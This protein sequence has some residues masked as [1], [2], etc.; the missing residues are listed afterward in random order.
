M[1]VLSLPATLT[2]PPPL[3]D[4]QIAEDVLGGLLCPQLQRQFKLCTSTDLQTGLL[5]ASII[6]ARIATLSEKL[7]LYR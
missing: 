7:T 5:L 2:R 6:C 1:L 3:S 4:P